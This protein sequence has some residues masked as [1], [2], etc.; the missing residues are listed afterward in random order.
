MKKSAYQFL[1]QKKA[2]EPFIDYIFDNLKSKS[3][4]INEIAAKCFVS[5]STITRYFK[6]N[7]WEGFR[8]FKFIL[9]NELNNIDNDEK[10]SS[11]LNKNVIASLESTDNLVSATDYDQ[12]TQLIKNSQKI[13]IVSIGGNVPAALELRNRLLRF[14]FDVFF[15]TDQH[16]SYVY[17]KKL[18]QNDLIIAISYTG[19]TKEVLKIV[20]SAHK[21][22]VKIMA[23]T[24]NYDSDLFELSDLVL[25]ID[26]K[27][28]LARV[29]S[30]EARITIFYVIL[31]LSLCIYESDPEKYQK[32]IFSNSY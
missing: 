22:E 17:S 24:R 19:N 10:L 8:E 25:R 16:Y 1:L 31:K 13:M 5:K 2:E 18:N 29:I 21:N 27:E 4:E 20:K 3:L 9:M 14:G 7:G 12:A 26:S 6:Q 30:I 15:E 23:I 11:N 28:G 32:I